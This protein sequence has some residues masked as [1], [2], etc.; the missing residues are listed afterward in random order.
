[1]KKYPSAR[2]KTA[3]ARADKRVLPVDRDPQQGNAAL[4]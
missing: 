1:M 2:Q 4:D 3:L